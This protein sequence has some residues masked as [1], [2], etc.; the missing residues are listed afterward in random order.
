MLLSLERK[1]REMFI[2]NFSTAN[3]INAT[4]NL[5]NRQPKWGHMSLTITRNT[6]IWFINYYNIIYLSVLT[7]FQ[8]IWKGRTRVCRPRVCDTDRIASLIVFSV[9]CRVRYEEWIECQDMGK[10]MSVVWWAWR[11]TIAEKSFLQFAMENGNR[12]TYYRLCWIAK[13]KRAQFVHYISCVR[14]LWWIPYRLSSLS[15]KFI[16]MI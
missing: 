4:F 6:P 7:I 14:R 3:K 8:L 16:L 2:I 1:R 12:S 15:Y 10:N 13:A 9:A 11:T 5:N